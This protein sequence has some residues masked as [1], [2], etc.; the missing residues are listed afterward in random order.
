[1]E[2]FQRQRVGS[3]TELQRVHG[4]AL[5][6]L[7]GRRLDAVWVA[8]EEGGEAWLPD[9]PVVLEFD[10]RRLEL[11]CFGVGTTS[12]TWETLDLHARPDVYGILGRWR[13]N[14]LPTFMAVAG[15]VLRDVGWLEYRFDRTLVGEHGNAWLFTG[16]EFVF[17]RGFLSVHNG[18]D[19][20]AFGTE[21]LVGQE[22]R[23][24]RV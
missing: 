20:N 15:K 4:E 9:A 16:L 11:D 24:G 23:R 7:I 22:F 10:D 19:E 17:D 21:P 18:L 12:V 2:G 3:V 8:W 14:A 5:R 13:A 6:G 1:M